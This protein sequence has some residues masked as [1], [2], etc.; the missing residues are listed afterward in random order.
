[1]ELK[2]DSKGKKYVLTY[3]GDNIIVKPTA[4][5]KPTTVPAPEPTTESKQ[6]NEMTHEEQVVE[7][8]NKVRTKEGL[9]AL[10]IDSVIAEAAAIRAKEIRSCYSHTRP[11]GTG[12]RDLLVEFGFS[13]GKAFNSGENLVGGFKTPEAAMSSWMG[14][15]GH[16]TNIL[17]PDFTSIGVGYYHGDDGYDYWV[18]IFIVG[19]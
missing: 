6:T 7:L 8:V 17:D 4:T 1:M 11:D 15:P 12:F 2:Y 16:K 3:K 19:D 18:Q 10:K 5:P 14:S 13:K 9:A